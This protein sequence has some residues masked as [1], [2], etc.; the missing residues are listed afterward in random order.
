[1]NNDIRAN[2]VKELALGL[3]VSKDYN[4]LEDLEIMEG[5]RF[6]YLS[7]LN[8]GWH[9]LQ[10]D[11]LNVVGSYEMIFRL[12]PVPVKGIYEIRYAVQNNS[13]NRG[14]CQVYFGSDKNRMPAVG[15]PLDLRIGGQSPLVGWQ[16]DET[17]DDDFNAEVD[18]KMRN[19]G[20]M[21]GSEYY[22]AGTSSA[23]MARATQ[24]TTRRIIVRQEMDPE[25]TYYLKFKTVLEK[26]ELQFY[27]D[28][29][30]FCAKE[31][32]DNPQ[33]PEDIW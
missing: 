10:G 23:P 33:T 19:L 22:H 9:N 8:R 11:E 29:L 13:S 3:P 17:D 30:E 16:K 20:F 32:Y 27:M 14:M 2:R 15:I 5:T 25:K 4:Y 18:K 31:V 7:G 26:T 6:Y 12:P 21:K 1:M 28:Y 24:T